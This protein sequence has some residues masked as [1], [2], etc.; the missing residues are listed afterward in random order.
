MPNLVAAV[1]F[2]AIVAAVAATGSA[3]S[4]A[5]AEHKCDPVTD[6]GWSVVPAQEIVGVVDSA[7]HRSAP[8]G[9]WY[10]DRVTTV[11]PFCH[12]FNAIGEYS[13]RSYSLSPVA[14]EE[15][16]AICRDDA[17][18]GSV[19]IAPYPGPCPPVAAAPQ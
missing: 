11:L 12:Y 8:A 15:Q 2:A 16:V 4:A 13:L 1:A 17:K 18:G 3:S 6:E 7:P 10:V 19:A 14:S 5:A 9:S